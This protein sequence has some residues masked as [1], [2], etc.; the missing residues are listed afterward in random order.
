MNCIRGSKVSAVVTVKGE[1]LYVT[2]F[3]PDQLWEGYLIP[4]VF[5]LFAWFFGHMQQRLVDRGADVSKIHW[6]AW[7]SEVDLD[8]DF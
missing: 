5:R 8:E 6:S 7:R 4:K 1:Q 2:D 3:M